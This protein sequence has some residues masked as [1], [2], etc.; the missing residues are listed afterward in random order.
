MS[1]WKNW[2]IAAVTGT[3]RKLNSFPARAIRTALFQKARH[4]SGE[5]CKHESKFINKH[6]YFRYCEWT[7]CFKCFD[8]F[9]GNAV[10]VETMFGHRIIR[11][12]TFQPY[13]F[14][15]SRPER[16]VHC[17]LCC[18]KF[19]EVCVL[20]CM[21]SCEP[22][23][24]DRCRDKAGIP[25]VKVRASRLPTTECDM[26]I[27]RYIQSENLNLDNTLTIRLLSEMN[28]EM[29]VPDRFKKVLS[30]PDKIKYQNYTLFTFMDSGAERD[31]CFFSVFF[32]LF[33]DH[34]QESNWD[35][36]Y[37]SYIDSV[38]FL[39]V[40]RTLVYRFVLLGLFE[41]LKNKGYR[42]I[43]LWSCPP[44]DNQDYIFHKKPE[45]MK[46]PT[47]ARLAKWYRELLKMGTERGVIAS[48]SGIQ[49]AVKDINGLPVMEGDN[50]VTRLNEAIV[51]IEKERSKFYNEIKK[52]MA[53][54]TKETQENKK[55]DIRGQME[56]LRMKQKEKG[57]NTRLWELLTVQIAGF[58]SEYFVISLSPKR[59]MKN[60]KFT[61][62]KLSKSRTWLNDRHLFMDF[63]WGHILEFSTERRAQY[64]T[65][66]MLWRIF[67]DNG[68]C[69]KCPSSSENGVTT[70]CLCR[71]CDS[72]N[73]STFH[74][75]E[76]EEDV[77]M[78]FS[79]SAFDE[80]LN[81]MELSAGEDQESSDDDPGS[82][83]MLVDHD[84]AVPGPSE[85]VGNQSDN[86]QPIPLSTPEINSDTVN[87]NQSSPELVTVTPENCPQALKTSRSDSGLESMGSSPVLD[88]DYNSESESVLSNEPETSR[89]R[90][91]PI[92]KDQTRPVASKTAQE[93]TN[94]AIEEAIIIDS[95]S[96]DSTS[97][98]ARVVIVDLT[99]TLRCTALRK[100]SRDF[101][102]LTDC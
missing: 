53:Q 102:D 48:Y 95:D 89:F 34:C 58:N 70:Q 25:K 41:F 83:N 36:A 19:H 7:Y 28:Q 29:V 59:K 30:G 6:S 13:F 85:S 98:T 81:A 50:W 88:L 93:A 67:I 20:H 3:C 91:E 55:I 86:M 60:I 77:A 42:K 14:P 78:S 92:K 63:F 2:A 51:I 18:K 47:S 1:S 69:V 65:F 46:M 100:L 57:F 94:S 68:L 35:S 64:S 54:H 62:D 71:T 66:V 12:Q 21:F 10:E 49:D 38:N 84:Y 87:Q 22:F 45:K 5:F 44:T 37:I 56:S 8:N 26:F 96:D 39:P 80:I 16:F 75:T 43:Y 32:Q 40:N 90:T 97:N 27:N 52:L 82:M 11:K 79:D 99:Q 72:K 61:D 33:G 4:T 74:D 101:Y 73:Q 24:C 76:G 9:P 31:I 23:I 15:K 17:E